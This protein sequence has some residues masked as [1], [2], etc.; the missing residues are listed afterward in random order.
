MNRRPRFKNHRRQ[1]P[2][3][4][5]RRGFWEKR[6]FYPVRT[7]EVHQERANSRWFWLGFKRPPRS[8][9]RW[10]LKSSN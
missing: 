7:R 1:L 4:D 9:W 8:T 10:L 6:E 2:M 3:A 5:Y